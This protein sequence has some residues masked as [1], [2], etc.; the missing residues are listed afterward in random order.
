VNRQFMLCISSTTIV[1]LQLLSVVDVRSC[2][3]MSLQ[4]NHQVSIVPTIVSLAASGGVCKRRS[5]LILAP[6]PVLV[7]V[8]YVDTVVAATEVRDVDVGGGFDLLSNSRV[9]E[10]DT[11]YPPSMVGI[12]DCERTVL[13]VEGDTYQAETAFRCLGGTT[14]PTGLKVGKV[15]SY[16]VKYVTS[17]SI[18]TSFV[19]ADR[20]FEMTCRNMNPDV[21]W[22]VDTPNI[23]RHGNAKLIV[24]RRS[25]EVPNDN[26]FGFDELSRVDDGIVTRCV[27][28][29]RRYRRG[30]DD[31]GNRVVDGL[32]IV[33]TFRVLDGIA[34]IEYPTSTTKSRIRLTRP[35][36]V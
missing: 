20:G 9:T 4:Q 3:G 14:T 8:P 21:D 29:K 26:G 11:I 17:P 34:G 16:Q 15:E 2:W 18:G 31:R 28:V 7:L 24:V 6:I 30:F 5:V 36:T 33:K 32:E 27:Q 22:M 35:T 13:A 25:V 23:L 1:M 12:W 10:K 19:V